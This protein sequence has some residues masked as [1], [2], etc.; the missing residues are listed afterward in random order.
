VSDAAG[1]R[2]GLRSPAPRRST[3][4]GFLRT[5]WAVRD[6][7]HLL[8]RLVGLYVACWAVLL[9]LPLDLTMRPAEILQKYREGR[10][11]LALS[12]P[13]ALTVSN[14]VGWGLDVL[15]ALPVGILAAGAWTRHGRLRGTARA[16][17]L[18]IAAVVIAE[19]VQVLVV[20]R[21]T[22]VVDVLARAAGA[23]SG[24][25]A[26]YWLGQGLGYGSAGSARRAGAAR[27]RIAA[28]GWIVVLMLYHWNPFNFS[29]ET[30]VPGVRWARLSLVP[31]VNY[32]VP[33]AFAA[34]DDLVTKTLLALPLGLLL[35]LSARPRRPGVRPGKAVPLVVAAAIV[36][37]IE[38]G[39]LFLPSRV[40]DVTDVLTQEL[41]AAAGVFVALRRD[42]LASEDRP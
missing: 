34:F 19:C 32:E 1:L 7:W 30:T 41:A 40:P 35:G 15:A 17:A 28:L 3:L 2:S 29:I 26:A 31:F 16:V 33:S 20:S 27:Y 11:D 39:Q 6:R 13:V 23:A 14:A 4:T 36:G 42:P 8:I 9:W 21:S 37:A 24:V 12:T 38:I 22:R 25:Q 5:L 18:A 10:I